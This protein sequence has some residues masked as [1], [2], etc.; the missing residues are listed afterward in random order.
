MSDSNRPRTGNIQETAENHKSEENNSS[1]SIFELIVHKV[2]VSRYI[3]SE[4]KF[5]Y[6]NECL[7][8]LLGY[9]E[10]EF[11]S[12]NILLETVVHP[13]DLSVVQTRITEN[14]GI[15]S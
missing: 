10:E 4:G 13:E 5:V 14:S 3:M 15:A 12:G 6:V 9:T 2:P 7:C 8:G 11:L 1:S